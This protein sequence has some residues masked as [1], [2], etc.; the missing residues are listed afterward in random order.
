MNNQQAKDKT[1]ELRNE[2]TELKEALSGDFRQYSDEN[3]LTIKLDSV[4]ED[5]DYIYM[6]LSSGDRKG[7]NL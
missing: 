1:I 7:K 6:M 4:I 3:P 2:A 5:L